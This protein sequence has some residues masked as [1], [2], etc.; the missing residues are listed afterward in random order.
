MSNVNIVILILANL[1]PIFGVLYLGWS[2]PN[3]LYLYWAESAIIGFFNILKMATAQGGEPPKNKL[4]FTFFFMIHYGLFMVV[5][6]VFL[7]IILLKVFKAQGLNVGL[8]SSIR[9]GLIL[10]FLSYGSS[11]LA[12]YI[13]KGEYKSASEKF[14]LLQPYGRIVVMHLTI[15][16]GTAIIWLSG[17]SIVLLV[18]LVLFKMIADLVSQLVARHKK[19]ARG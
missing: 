16:L 13:G 9:W 11:F 4:F 19:T 14:L 7:T 12:N 3:I 10:L 18:L 15:L 17:P 6:F 1:F 2:L 8:L 5:H